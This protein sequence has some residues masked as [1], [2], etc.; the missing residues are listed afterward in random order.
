M[1]AK[2]FFEVFLMQVSVI[3]SVISKKTET[4]MWLRDYLCIRKIF[5]SP[6]PISGFMF[7]AMTSVFRADAEECLEMMTWGEVN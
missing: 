2:K 7:F 4:V 3:K 5:C 6:V 1:I